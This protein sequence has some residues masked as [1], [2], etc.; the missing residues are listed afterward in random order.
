[1]RTGKYLTNL[2]VNDLENNPYLGVIK[3]MRAQLKALQKEC[4]VEFVVAKGW[5]ANPLLKVWRALPFT[6]LAARWQFFPEFADIDFLYVRYPMSDLHLCRLLEIVKTKNSKCKIIVEIPTFPY[7]KEL[8]G[9]KGL[10]VKWKDQLYRN[11]LAKSVDRFVVF[12]KVGDVYGVP[13]I[14]TINGIDVDAIKPVAP[15]T[16]TQDIHLIAVALFAWWHGY[17]RL[18]EG[19]SVYYKQGGKRHIVLHMVGIGPEVPRL[20]QLANDLGLSAQVIFHGMLNGDALDAI[21]NES[22]V[23][24]ET[25]AMHRKGDI[26]SSSLK[27]REYLAKG[28]PFIY[29]TQIDVFPYND[30]PYALHLPEDESPIDIESVIDFHDR[31][32][33]DKQKSPEQIAAEIR[34]FAYQHCDMHQTMKPVIDYINE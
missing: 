7:D 31:I 9:P 15:K 23:A 20:Q 8:V 22:S 19:L 1:M 6:P 34:N 18:I 27:T 30:Y 24:V 26:I 3:K 5:G 16:P 32:Y 21:Y 25:L 33:F 29:A 10:P 14:Q 13:T 17:D 11:R 4:Q 12:G 28:L 2:N